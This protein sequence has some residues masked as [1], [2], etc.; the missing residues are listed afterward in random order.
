MIEA[1]DF[2]AVE[3]VHAFTPC[4]RSAFRIRECLGHR[5]MSSREA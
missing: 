3:Q 5:A 4:W 2:D 1:E